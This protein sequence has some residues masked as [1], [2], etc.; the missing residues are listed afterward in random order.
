VEKADMCVAAQRK[1]RVAAEKRRLKAVRF[2]TLA[3]ICEVLDCQPSDL[4]EY[5][6]Q[7]DG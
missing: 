5:K 4:L 6:P 1:Q 7:G 3:K 2:E